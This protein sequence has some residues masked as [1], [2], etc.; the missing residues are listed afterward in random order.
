MIHRLLDDKKYYLD[1]LLL[2]DEQE[3]MID[4]YLERGEMF[5]LSV[6]GNVV[7]ICVVTDE[8]N[9]ICELKNIA[10]RPE[11]QRKGLGTQLLQYISEEYSENFHTLLVGTGDS[12]FTV[13]FYKNNGFTESHKEENFFTNNYH[14]PIFEDGVQLVDMIYLK[15]DLNR[16]E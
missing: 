2:G 15:K 10:V 6:D 14:E 16:V 7:A 12:P 9:G 1:L 5:T 11:S 3:D 8:E 4:R 13:L